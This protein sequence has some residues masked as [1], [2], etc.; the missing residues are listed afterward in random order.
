MALLLIAKAVAELGIEAPGRPPTRFRPRLEPLADRWLP[1]Q[2]GLTVRSLADAGPGT[3][4]AAIVTAN[5]G[6]Q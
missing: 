3:L 4:R 1:S 6:S 5:A 2:I